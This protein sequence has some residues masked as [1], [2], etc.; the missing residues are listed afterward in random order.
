MLLIAGARQAR[1]D[2]GQ[3]GDGFLDA[4]GLDQPQ[5]APLAD[6]LQGDQVL[7]QR[8][9]VRSPERL[10]ICVLVPSQ[11]LVAPCRRQ[12]HAQRWHIRMIC[13]AVEWPAADKHVVAV[14]LGRLTRLIRPFRPRHHVEKRNDIAAAGLLKR[15]ER[16][17][18]C[19]YK[20]APSSPAGLGSHVG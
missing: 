5:R 12:E 19:G 15:D 11:Q 7:T 10:P 4:P 9:E 6:L 2:A 17:R 13:I 8:R 20:K 16:H 3:L 1:P 18:V 14:I